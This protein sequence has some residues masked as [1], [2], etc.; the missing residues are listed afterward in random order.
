MVS[1]FFTMI[2]LFSLNFLVI[3]PEPLNCKERTMDLGSQDK[4][5][6][7]FFSFK[8]WFALSIG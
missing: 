6:P 5:M 8:A 7:I 1:W 2:S 3:L 4:V